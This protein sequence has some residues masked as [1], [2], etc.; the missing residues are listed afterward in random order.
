MVLAK[1]LLREDLEENTCIEP[2]NDDDDDDDN[3][4]SKILCINKNAS[5]SVSASAS[6]SSPASFWNNLKTCCSSQSLA[7]V[8]ACLLLFS[9]MYRATSYANMGSYYEDMYGVEPHTRGYIQ[10]YQRI[11]AF[12]VQSTL[13]QPIL[14]RTGG[15]HRAVY[16]AAI[17][18]AGASFLETKKNFYI[19]LVVTS[20]SIALSISMM[21]ISLRSLLTQSAPEDA[22]FSIF[23]ALDVLKNATAITVPFYRAFLFKYMTATSDNNDDG[24]NTE[25]ISMDGDPDP[26]S[27]I[28][29]A[30]CHWIVAALIMVYLLGNGQKK[31]RPESLSTKKDL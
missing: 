5:A 15:E 26:V 1:I 28:L 17:L 29:C 19:F 6:S 18:L 9:W 25:S 8:I 13:I 4:D 7:A 10:S 22:I 12:I 16:L 27:W 20:P 24:N 21:G 11:L 14:A 30:G 23:A 2:T 31:S 3:C